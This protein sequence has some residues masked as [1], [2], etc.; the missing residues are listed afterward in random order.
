MP[1][2]K[3]KYFIICSLLLVM[4]SCTPSITTPS[5][6]VEAKAANLEDL[7]DS[8]KSAKHEEYKNYNININDWFGDFLVSDY[9]SS[10]I[11]KFNVSASSYFEN[12]KS[13]GSCKFG[14]EYEIPNVYMLNFL[15]TEF[16]IKLVDDSLEEEY[17]LFK[18]CQQVDNV[19]STIEIDTSLIEREVKLYYTTSNHHAWADFY[20]LEFKNLYTDI[21]VEVECI[22]MK[23]KD[24]YKF[25]NNKYKVRET[26]ISIEHFYPKAITD[27]GIVYYKMMARIPAKDLLYLVSDEYSQNEKYEVFD[28]KFKSILDEYINKYEKF[29]LRA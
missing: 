26:I 19:L 1:K 11:I 22:K 18:V 29:E 2:R 14:N 28:L 6:Y 8:L 16:E 27:N 15:K 7:E 20:E 4:I 23:I 10:D 9:R 24:Y 21:D 17:F 13:V 3:I 25:N 5:V 12:G